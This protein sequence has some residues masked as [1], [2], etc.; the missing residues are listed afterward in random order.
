[1]AAWQTEAEMLG[2]QSNWLNISLANSTKAILS[3]IDWT[4]YPGAG[5]ADYGDYPPPA[6]LQAQYGRVKAQFGHLR[7]W[8]AAH[9]GHIIEV[10]RWGVTDAYSYANDIPSRRIDQTTGFDRDGIAKQIYYAQSG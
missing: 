3:E 9:P 2:A 5:T 10:S 8:D 7:T 1:M 4:L 6:V